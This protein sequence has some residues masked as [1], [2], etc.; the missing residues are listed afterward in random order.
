MLQSFK[1]WMMNSGV[2][3]IIKSDITVDYMP[4]LDIVCMLNT[5]TFTI[6]HTHS[7]VNIQCEVERGNVCMGK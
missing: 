4:S 2:C 5:H 1:L 3:D 7:H 6:T